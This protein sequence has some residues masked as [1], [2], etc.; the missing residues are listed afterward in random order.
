MLH[1]LLKIKLKVTIFDWDLRIMEN[2]FEVSFNSPQCGWM[3]IGFKDDENE[4]HSTTAYA[5]HERA[6]PELLHILTRLLGQEDFRETL[7]WNRNPEEFDFVFTKKG[8][9][10]F[11]E[12]YQYPTEERLEKE[13]VFAHAGDCLQVAESFFETIVQLYESRETDEFH[14]NWHQPFPYAEFEKFENALKKL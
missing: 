13:I 14:S 8:D 7:L 2:N 3:S 12:I 9:E 6:L 10:A 11:L 5:P 4:F 1:R